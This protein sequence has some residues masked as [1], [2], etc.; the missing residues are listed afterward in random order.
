M[1]RFYSWSPGEILDLDFDEFEL[2]YQ[3]I[4]PLEAQEFLMQLKVM[5]WP[6]MK[7]NARQKLHAQMRNV[8]YAN[9]KVGAS[10]KTKVSNEDLAKILSKR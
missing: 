1:A 10:K 6:N 2:F 4:D 8:A 7:D 3:A 5:D 9:S